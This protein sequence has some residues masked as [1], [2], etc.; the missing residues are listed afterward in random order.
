ML[1]SVCWAGLFLYNG[2]TK[3]DGIHAGDAW[4]AAAP[5]IIRLLILFVLH[6][7]PNGSRRFR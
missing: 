2:A 1:F 4:L 6:G 5:F 7:L 3:I